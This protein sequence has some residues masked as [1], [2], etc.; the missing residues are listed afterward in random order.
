MLS[1]YRF[2]F[3]CQLFFCSLHGRSASQVNDCASVSARFLQLWIFSLQ[4]D[5]HT[6]WMY[7]NNSGLNE[8][9][10]KLLATEYA[11]IWPKW[12]NTKIIHVYWMWIHSAPT[13]HN[14]IRKRIGRTVAERAQH[15]SSVA[16]IQCN[17]STNVVGEKSEAI[18]RM[19]YVFFL[20]C[21]LYVRI[22]V[23]VQWHL[24]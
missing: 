3:W 20:V 18:E 12:M 9:T 21:L 17:V 13:P 15:N 4:T 7:A 22:C 8:N 1:T 19:C 11:R 16:L 23:F 10:F 14:F 2:I 5:T 6:R 24:V